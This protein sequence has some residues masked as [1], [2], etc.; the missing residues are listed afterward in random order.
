MTITGNNSTYEGGGIYGK[1]AIT[2][3]DATVT[4][5]NRYDVYYDGE[6]KQLLNSLFPARCRPVITPIMIGSCPFLYQA[7]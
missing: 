7:H 5:N 3:A 2:L 1:G 6:E 4:G